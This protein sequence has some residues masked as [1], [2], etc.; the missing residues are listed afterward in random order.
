LMLPACLQ[1]T[2]RLNECGCLFSEVVDPMDPMTESI[3]LGGRQGR[4]E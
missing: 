3:G 4:A 2:Q 1:Q